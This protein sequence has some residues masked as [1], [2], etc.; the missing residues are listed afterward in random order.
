MRVAQ[1]RRIVILVSS[2]LW[3]TGLAAAERDLIP[4]ALTV[5]CDDSVLRNELLS[6]VGREL[7]SISD[8]QVSL[9]P[10]K[11][12]GLVSLNVVA[13]TTC[14]DLA[15]ALS[16]AMHQRY[17]PMPADPYLDLFLG[18]GVLTGRRD[19]IKKLAKQLVASFDASALNEWRRDNERLQRAMEKWRNEKKDH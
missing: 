7:K 9:E 15:V 17:Y 16:Y 18:N 19:D 2:V 6:F 3:A 13:V 11:T 4:I 8:V 10:A 5:E 14:S 12:G 1:L